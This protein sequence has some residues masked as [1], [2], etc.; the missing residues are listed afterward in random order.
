MATP[1]L[2]ESTPEVTLDYS[3]S[4][5]AAEIPAAQVEAAAALRTELDRFDSVLVEPDDQRAAH[6]EALL[7]G[8]SSAWRGTAGGTGYLAVVSQGVA[9]GL[10]QISVVVPEQLRLS[11]NSGRFPVEVSNALAVPVQVRL[12]FASSN[13]DRLEVSDSELVEVPAGSKAQV[14]VEATATANGRVPVTVTL[15]TPD[16]ERFGVPHRFEVVATNYDTLSWI[17]VGGAA[18]LLFIAAGFR[19]VRRIR[20]SRK[21]EPL[22]SADATTPAAEAAARQHEEVR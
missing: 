9:N 18:A 16:G 10:Q 8:V 20:R 13:P 2:A 19:V 15:Q 22:A 4:D 11:S 1:E 6:D 5:A 3:D 7:R 12:A 14:D 17:I 21:P